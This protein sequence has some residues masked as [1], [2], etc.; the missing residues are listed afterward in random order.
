MA[1][2]DFRN[3]SIWNKI[4]TRDLNLQ[5]IYST[6]VFISTIFFYRK[7]K[8]KKVVYSLLDNITMML[9]FKF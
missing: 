4:D 8:N 7:L 5:K 2:E 9:Q 3:T 1:D 6:Y